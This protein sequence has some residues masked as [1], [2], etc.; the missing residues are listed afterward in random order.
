MINMSRSDR[1]V[2]DILVLAA[3]PGPEQLFSFQ[4]ISHLEHSI[5]L[6]LSDL[7]QIKEIG[8]SLEDN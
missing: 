2:V 8:L 3:S 4:D 6:S 7:H 5:V 1:S